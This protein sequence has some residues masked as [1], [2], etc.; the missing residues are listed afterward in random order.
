[1]SNQAFVAAVAQGGDLTADCEL[2]SSSSEHTPAAPLLEL[3]SNTTAVRV[4]HERARGGGRGGG[5]GGSY[6]GGEA[7]AGSATSGGVAVD[8]TIGYTGSC[9]ACPENCSHIGA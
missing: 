1:M 6:T 4:H 8:S 7:A 2:S 5:G 3:R 9:T